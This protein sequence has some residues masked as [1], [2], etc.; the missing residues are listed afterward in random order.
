MTRNISSDAARK[1]LFWLWVAFFAVNT[2]AIIYLYA[3]HWIESDNF[4]AAIEALASTYE[5]YLGMMVA[6]YFTAGA[7]ARTQTRAGMPFAVA[8]LGSLAWN[9]PVTLFIVRLVARTGTIE[10]SIQQITFL[11]SRFSWLVAAAIGYYFANPSAT[12][13]HG[14]PVPPKK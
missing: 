4:H 3:G 14:A 9:V 12:H 1:V 5:T 2:A 8:L 11:A 13:D 10:D 7:H 6:F